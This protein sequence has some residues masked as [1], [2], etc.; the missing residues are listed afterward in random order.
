[1]GRKVYGEVT[2]LTRDRTPVSAYDIAAPTLLLRGEHSP[3]AAR[4]VARIFAHALPN[5]DLVD[6]HGAGHMGP[7]THA[8][9]VNTLVAMNAMR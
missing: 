4:A 6:A 7:I 8:A 2:S 5:A 9:E 1:M 3:V